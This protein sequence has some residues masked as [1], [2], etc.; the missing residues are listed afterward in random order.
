MTAG[1]TNGN[2]D[3]CGAHP[4]N[5][6]TSDSHSPIRRRDLNCSTS[7]PLYS[8]LHDLTNAGKLKDEANSP[9]TTSSSAAAAATGNQP[10]CEAYVMTGERVLKLTKNPSL[11]PKYQKKVDSL[12]TQQNFRKSNAAAA[13]V[14]ASAATSRHNKSTPSSPVDTEYAARDEDV[15]AKCASANTSP[16][17]LGAPLKMVEAMTQSERSTAFVATVSKSDDYI[18]YSK[19]SVSMSSTSVQVDDEDITSSLNTL[20][21]TKSDEQFRQQQQQLQRRHQRHHKTDEACGADLDDDDQRVLWSC[22]AAVR[23]NAARSSSTIASSENISSQPSITPPSPTSVSSSVMSSSSS[24]SSVTADRKRPQGAGCSPHHHHHRRHPHSSNSG[25]SSQI[26]ALS[27]ISSPD[28][29]EE[30]SDLLNS[31]D[32]GM[33]VTDPSDSDST[34]LASEPKIRRLNKCVGSDNHELNGLAADKSNH[35][36]VIQVGIDSVVYTY[37][38]S[39]SDKSRPVAYIKL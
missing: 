28:Y 25:D 13:T 37:T 1:L 33:E 35:R 6:N 22:T 21:D 27:N 39:Y 7:Q 15:E 9:S 24:S 34:L 2:G 4:N 26:E 12:K 23:P 17:T 30:A 20:L 10:L 32:I 36:I 11:A 29:Q 31:N 14:A 8:P 16:I 3:A 19:S 38:A 5:I 18:Q